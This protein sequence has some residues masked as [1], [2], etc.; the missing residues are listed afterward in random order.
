MG[1][2]GHTVD[3]VNDGL[4]VITVAVALLG[5]CLAWYTGVFF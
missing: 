1:N 3:T 4:S 5:I 2:D